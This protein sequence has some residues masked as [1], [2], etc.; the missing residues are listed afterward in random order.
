MTLPEQVLREACREQELDADGAVPLSCSSNAIYLLPVH[1]LVA[2]VTIGTANLLDR[3]ERAHAVSRW[4]VAHDFRAV[5]PAPDRPPVPIG[6]DAAV[7][8]WIYY[9]QEAHPD[10]GAAVMGRLLR[11][12]H[13][14][15]RPPMELPQWVPLES[16]YNTLI[17]DTLARAL[18]DNERSWL[19]RH[20]HALRVELDE[21]SWPLGHGLIHGDAWA[22]NLLWDGPAA[23]AR[24]C[25]WDWTSIGPREVDLVPTWHAHVRYGRGSDWVREFIAEYGHDLGAWEGYDALL[26]MRDLVQLS[27]PIRSAHE[28]PNHAAALRQRFNDIRTGRRRTTWRMR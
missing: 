20:I 3:A 6:Q 16:L 27:G 7:S 1:G 12:L 14:I 9:S 11:E 15:E 8:F 23:T 24:L 21:L 5:E 18:T 28:S 25:D 13:K 26:R 19:L 4:L 17:D 2:R 10:L 22:G